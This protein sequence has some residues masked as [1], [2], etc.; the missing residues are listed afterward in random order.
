LV[1]E[2]VFSGQPSVA[3]KLIQI[4]SSICGRPSY[5]SLA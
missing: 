4:H 1:L 3:R 5:F 2:V